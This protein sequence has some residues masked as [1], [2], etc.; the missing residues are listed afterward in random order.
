MWKWLI[1]IKSWPNVILLASFNDSIKTICK[2]DV[3]QFITHI[4]RATTEYGEKKKNCRGQIT[5]DVC[6]NKATT[7][8]YRIEAG[9]WERNGQTWF[10]PQ[11]R[12]NAFFPFFFL[13]FR[14]YKWSNWV[15][16]NCRLAICM[17][18]F[19][20]KLPK[21]INTQAV[22]W[23]C[24]PRDAAWFVPV[25]GLNLIPCIE[26]NTSI[27]LW[28]TDHFVRCGVA[29]ARSCVNSRFCVVLHMWC[30]REFLYL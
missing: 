7:Q 19:V 29:V 5:H 14:K 8:C 28:T 30:A 6:I 26:H 15:S 16:E 22:R 13:L 3:F 21:H 17:K 23:S 11:K 9:E 25:V 1:S 10:D 4:E 12:N 18:W 2:L 24:I 27:E 20:I